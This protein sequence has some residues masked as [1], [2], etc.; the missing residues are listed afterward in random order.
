MRNSLKIINWIIQNTEWLF[1]GIGIFVMK[2][3][4][5]AITAI[6]KF[7][8]RR[9]S[10]KQNS[11]NVSIFKQNPTNSSFIAVNEATNSPITQIGNQN[12]YYQSDMQ[13]KLSDKTISENREMLLMYLQNALERLT[14]AYSEINDFVTTGKDGNIGGAIFCINRAIIDDQWSEALKQSDL[15]PK[16][17]MKIKEWFTRIKN[18]TKIANQ[19]A[20]NDLSKFNKNIDSVLN[21]FEIKNIMNKLNKEVD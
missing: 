13:K 19:S 3:I 11:N 14:S 7:Y 20:I 18:L 2:V 8:N 10:K 16:T 5:T 4:M 15:T 1:S 17:A 21:D 9:K 6:I 12:N